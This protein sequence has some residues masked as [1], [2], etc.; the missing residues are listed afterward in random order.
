MEEQF[1]DKEKTLFAHFEEIA[2]CKLIPLMYNYI[3]LRP[4]FGTIFISA[5]FGLE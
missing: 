4:N 5:M 3:F 1:Y 2:D